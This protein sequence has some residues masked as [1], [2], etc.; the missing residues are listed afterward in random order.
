MSGN[1][2]RSLRLACKLEF[3]RGLTTSNSD[4]VRTE[5]DCEIPTPSIL[6]LEEIKDAYDEVVDRLTEYQASKPVH[7]RK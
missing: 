7:D 4:S 1:I 3:V 2:L 6:A 5:L